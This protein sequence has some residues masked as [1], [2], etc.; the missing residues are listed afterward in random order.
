MSITK[1]LAKMILCEHVHRPIKGTILL[2]GS[3]TIVPSE[4][5]VRS[6][7]Q[8][9]GIPE[10]DVV[11]E[12]DT[13]TRGAR[14]DS[15]SDKSF[16]ALFTDAECK[17]LDVTDYESADI[18]H[19]MNTEI[20]EALK[21]K[22]DFIY[23]GGAMDNLFNP[24]QFIVNCSELLAPGGRIVHCELASM[25]RGAY[26]MYSPNFFH[27]YYALN[28]YEDCKVFY[29]KFKWSMTMERWKLSMLQPFKDSEMKVHRNHTYSASMWPHV[30]IAI[31][32]KGAESTSQKMP[33]QSVYRPKDEDWETYLTSFRRFAQKERYPTGFGR[34][35]RYE[36]DLR[37]RLKVFLK[38]PLPFSATNTKYIQKL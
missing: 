34:P 36:L 16:F 20:P 7:L 12:R 33:I 14:E 17:S 4:K 15:I 11:I 8:E 37:K 2:M 3:Q 24:A 21:G 38:R 23:D 18:V 26:V 9:F 29:A 19:D 25:W 13:Y 27:D 32:E 30:V 35:T 6:Y 31:A 22:I 10:R 5:E 28:E 1:P